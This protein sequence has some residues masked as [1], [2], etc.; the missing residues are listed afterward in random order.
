MAD[1]HAAKYID[2]TALHW[3][4]DS[5]DTLRRLDEYR[6]RFPDKLLMY[7]ESSINSMFNG[8]P[9]VFQAEQVLTKFSDHDM[10]M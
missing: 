9:F 10:V 5:N 7:T 4:L 1:G 3:Y 8:E 2:G 6:K